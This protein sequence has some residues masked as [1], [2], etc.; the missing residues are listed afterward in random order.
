MGLAEVGGDQDDFVFIKIG[1]QGDRAGFGTFC[2]GGVQGNGFHACQEAG[3]G[4]A[5][6]AQ[7]DEGSVEIVEGAGKE[8]GT[9]WGRTKRLHPE[10]KPVWLGIRSFHRIDKF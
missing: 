5:A 6:F 8:P 2:A 1:Y 10:V 9:K 7:F 3:E 4:R